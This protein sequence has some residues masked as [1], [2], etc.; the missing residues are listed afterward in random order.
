MNRTPVVQI[1]AQYALSVAILS[2]FFLIPASRRLK[3]T[4]TEAALD[5]P[6]E[7]GYRNQAEQRPAEP[8]T[9]EDLAR[10]PLRRMGVGQASKLTTAQLAELITLIENQAPPADKP[11]ARKKS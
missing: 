7:A 3:A 5:C 1:V 4:S 8:K 2:P 9:S 10:K 11:R 6:A